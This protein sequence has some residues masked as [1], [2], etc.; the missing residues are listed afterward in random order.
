MARYTSFF[1]TVSSLTRLRRTLAETLTSC[2]LSLIYENEDYLVAKEKPGDVKLAQLAT[3]EVLI[4][5][6]TASEPSTKVNVV[7]KNEELPLHR[8]NHCQQVFEQVHQ[9]IS[10][11][12]L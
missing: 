10:G 5:P 3:V 9:A 6:P 7:V 11:S 4:N 8:D 1:R 2:D 12:A